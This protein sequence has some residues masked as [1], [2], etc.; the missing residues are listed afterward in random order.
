M[1]QKQFHLREMQL[2]DSLAVSDLIK[3]GDG[4]MTTYFEIEAYRAMIEFAELETVGVVA[5]VTDFDGLAGIATLRSGMCQFNGSV[6]PFII[7]DSLKVDERF[8]KQGLGTQLAQ[9]RIDYARQQFGED[10]VLLSATSTDNIASQNTM[11]KWC[12]EFTDP[13][14]IAL[15]R[16]SSR[17]PTDLQGITIRDAHPNEYEA[18]ANAQNAF[19]RDYN[20]YIP[21]SAERLAKD[22]SQS[23]NGQ[24]LTRHIVAVT[25]SGNLVAGGSARYRGDL[26]YD[27]ITPPPPL[28]LA[29]VFLR[30]LPPDG[31]LRDVQ[32]RGLWFAHGQ[33]TSLQHLLHTVRYDYHDKAPMIGLIYDKRSPFQALIK[34]SRF[35][36]IPQIIVGVKGPTLLE[37]DRLLYTFGRS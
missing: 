21:V 15:L 32:L 34:R 25:D 35:L 30:L 18:L 28:R 13:S 37:S 5:E 20:L 12:R 9:W 16:T 11:K 14:P 8:R 1:T 17:K 7:L 36:P 33:E 31:I 24:P 23:F 29:N 27:Q 3:Q 2:Q 10:V 6:L 26:M 22:V 19:Y 4:M